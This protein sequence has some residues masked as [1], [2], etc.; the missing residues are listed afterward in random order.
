MSERRNLQREKG[1][2]FWFSNNGRNISFTKEIDK[3]KK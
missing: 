3:A 2:F 1:F